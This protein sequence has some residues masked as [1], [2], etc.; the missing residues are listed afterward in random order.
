MTDH[1]VCLFLATECMGWTVYLPTVP[2]PSAEP[3]ISL[4]RCRWEP[5]DCDQYD[6][7]YLHQPNRL[8]VHW[9]PLVRDEHCAMVQDK[10]K[11]SADYKPI[12]KEWLAYIWDGKGGGCQHSDRKRAICFFAVQYLKAEAEK[13]KA[14]EKPEITFTPIDRMDAYKVYRVSGYNPANIK[15]LLDTVYN[16]CYRDNLTRATYVYLTPDMM[17]SFKHQLFDEGV[18]RDWEK[19]LV[20]VDEPMA[21][22]TRY[23]DIFVYEVARNPHMLASSSSGLIVYEI[24]EQD[25]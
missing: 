1:E 2:F 19:G 25:G 14:A 17:K 22:I 8:T 16:A 23:R 3:F 18:I 7:V 9:E 24:E 6:A 15:D 4:G 12:S 5:A 13:K 11:I 20:A 21:V 10:L